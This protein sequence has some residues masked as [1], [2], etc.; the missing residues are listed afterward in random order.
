MEHR[1]RSCSDAESLLVSLQTALEGT[2]ESRY[3]D[4]LRS[5]SSPQTSY[6][7]SQAVRLCDAETL[8]AT[9]RRAHAVLGDLGPSLDDDSLD[10]ERPL[11]EDSRPLTPPR[12]PQAEQEQQRPPTEQWQMVFGTEQWQVVFGTPVGSKE[13]RNASPPTAEVRRV[14]NLRSG[15]TANRTPSTA[16]P[17]ACGRSPRVE[18][19]EQ[20]VCRWDDAD[21]D[22][23]DDEESDDE[24]EAEAEAEA[25]QRPAWGRRAPREAP[26][27]APHP[28]EARGAVL[29][30]VGAAGLL[31]DLPSLR[32]SPS[33]QASPALGTSPLPPPASPPPPSPL[34]S[35]PPPQADPPPRSAWSSGSS[36]ARSQSR[37][38]HEPRGGSQAAA[39]DEQAATGRKTSEAAGTPRPS[40]RQESTARRRAGPPRHGWRVPLLQAAERAAAERE[41]AEAAGH[42]PVR[43]QGLGL[44][45]SKRRATPRFLLP[46]IQECLR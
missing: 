9:V 43:A 8:L 10:D 4:V 22:D 11:E 27:F 19:T 24:A 21:E 42:S 39:D 6:R 7:R 31:D 25:G 44:R 15:G 35:P 32:P 30:A 29:A 38:R 13:L 18:V 28:L 40:Q 5:D 16:G 45:G 33:P 36:A 12:Y 1:S 2:S 3:A 17:V 23:A 14:L 41:A 26:L 20:S 46:T 34:L 37:A